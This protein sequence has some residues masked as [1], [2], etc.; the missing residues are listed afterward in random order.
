MNFASFLS[1]KTMDPGVDITSLLDIGS[2]LRALAWKR[3][4][5]WQIQTSSCGVVL[6]LL[7]MLLFFLHFVQASQP[8]APLYI[9]GF[10]SARPEG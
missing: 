2:L 4:C 6:V 8:S 9:G 10:M 1:Q 7:R 5:F 3:S